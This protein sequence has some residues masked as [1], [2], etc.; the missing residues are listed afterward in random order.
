MT[1]ATKPEATEEIQPPMRKQ[2]I[3]I[4][5]GQV[6]WPPNTFITLDEVSSFLQSFV[7]R[8]WENKVYTGI[9]ADLRTKALQPPPVEESPEAPIEEPA[10]EAPIEETVLVPAPLKVVPNPEKA[11]VSEAEQLKA[12]LAEVD[13]LKAKMGL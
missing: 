13:A 3:F 12:K 9:M 2:V 7:Y 11:E 10:P 6:A 4:E 1:D 8:D 5:G